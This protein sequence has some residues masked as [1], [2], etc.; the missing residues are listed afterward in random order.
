MQYLI[1]FEVFES[2]FDAAEVQR[3]RGQ[4][5]A[6]FKERLNDPRIKAIGH[7]T[8]GRTGFMLAELG[9]H[10]E[11]LSLT[12]P[13]LDNVRFCVKP[14]VPMGTFLDNVEKMLG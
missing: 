3:L 2:I 10:E 9:S 5:F 6:F 4:A 8:H 14:V 12:G 7:F 13:F 11:V 1:E